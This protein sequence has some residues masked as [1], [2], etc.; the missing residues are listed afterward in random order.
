MPAAIVGRCA[1]FLFY[2]K[3]VIKLILNFAWLSF[4]S[5]LSS[6]A[7][8]SSSPWN[9]VNLMVLLMLPLLLPRPSTPVIT[10]SPANNRGHSNR[11]S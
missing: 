6:V 5:G 4:L 8:D 11:Q 7:L 3:C 10:L 1:V 9:R 2:E